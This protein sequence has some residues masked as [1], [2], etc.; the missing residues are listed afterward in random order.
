MPIHKNNHTTRET[1]QSH[2]SES[3]VPLL[4][5]PE[6]FHQYL[7]AQIREATR[8]VMEEI[9]CEELTQFV[10]ASWGNAHRSAGSIA[11]APTRAI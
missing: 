5:V 11:M 2:S 8:V 7:L 4:P 3:S 6:D 1:R 10:G 9:M